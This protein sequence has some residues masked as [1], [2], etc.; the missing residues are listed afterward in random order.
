MSIAL[1][2]PTRRLT[3]RCPQRLF[4]RSQALLA[5]SPAPE[6]RFEVDGSP[7]DRNCDCGCCKASGVSSGDEAKERA[8]SDGAA[9]VSLST[10]GSN[11]GCL[12]G[13]AEQRSAAAC[14]DLCTSGRTDR[15]PDNQTTKDRDV[16]IGYRS[17]VYKQSCLAPCA[18][19]VTWIYLQNGDCQAPWPA[20]R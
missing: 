7:S 12:P 4:L 14:L 18:R 11:W 6:R 8:V 19:H 5:V 16:H 13:E 9:N 17:S 20:P 1:A 10:P 2:A 3:P 15:Q